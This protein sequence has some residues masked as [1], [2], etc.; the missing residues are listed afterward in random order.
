[1][2]EGI[3]RQQPNK[4]DKISAFPR[5]FTS[6]YY[7]KKKFNCCLDTGNTTNGSNI[8]RRHIPEKKLPN[9]EKIGFNMSTNLFTYLAI[10][11]IY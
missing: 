6:L 4:F 1:M 7:P 9:E 10:K 3:F 5:T 8:L 11:K 2:C